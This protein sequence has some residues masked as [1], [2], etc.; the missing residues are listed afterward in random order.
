MT[1]HNPDLSVALFGVMTPAGIYRG[2]GAGDEGPAAE[3]PRQRG[4]RR[5]H[6]PRAPLH[7]HLQSRPAA[8][9]ERV[10]DTRRQQQKA[11]YQPPTCRL[12]QETGSLPNLPLGPLGV[13]ASLGS[14]HPPPCFLLPWARGTRSSFT[15]GSCLGSRRR[16]HWRPKKNVVLK[17]SRSS[18]A[19]RDVGT[20]D[21]GFCALPHLGY[22]F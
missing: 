22:K 7:P 14:G 21:L 5:A 18:E 2:G 4:W 3:P 9:E 15:R 19:A 10:T 20:R 1:S 12:A 16:I 11:T 13:L 17:F 6:L 8:G